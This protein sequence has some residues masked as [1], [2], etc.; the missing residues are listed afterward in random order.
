ML[1]AVPAALVT[2]SRHSVHRDDGALPD[3]EVSGTAREYGD[4]REGGTG[5]RSKGEEGA[6]G[7]RRYA[8]KGP[9]DNVARR[10]ALRESSEFG[11]IGSLG[12]GGVAKGGGG[13]GLGTGTGQGF[14][15]G[16]GR[17][18]GSALS[19]TPTAGG[20]RAPSAPW[21]RDRFDHAS[22][23]PFVR[24]KEDAR[25]TFSI[26][27]DTASYSWVRSQLARGYK[28][29]QG[30][31]RI[32]ELV[33]YFDYHY[34]QPTG[35][36]AFSVAAHVTE[37]PWAPRHRLLR[38]GIQ[39]K[40]LDLSH[41]PAANLVFLLD[42]SG[43]MQPENKLPLLK[44]GLRLLVDQLEA[45]DRVSIAVY[46]GAS[47][48]VLP[49]TPG[50]QKTRILHAIERLDAGGSTN[51]GEGIRLAYAQAKQS[52]MTGGINR[53]LLATDGDFNVG[54]TS[55][56]E[57]VDLIQKK[58]KQGVFLSVLGFGHGNYN[59][60][61]L[62]KLADKG[63]GNY[64]YI[65][66]LSEA[67]K[68]LVQQASGTLVTIAK[69]V[70]LQLEFN[71]RQVEAYRLIGYEN[72]V[73]EHR[74]FNDDRKDAG[75]LGAGHTVTALYEVI[76]AGMRVPE[77]SADG[78]KYQAPAGLTAA[79]D[80][81]EIVT[82]KLRYKAPDGDRSRLLEV[83]VQDGGSDFAGA[84]GDFRFAACVAAF[85]ML[86]RDSSYRGSWKLDDIR[87]VALAHAAG[88]EH[89]SEFV[90]LLDQARSVV[91]S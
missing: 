21:N 35:G 37:A 73:L 19:A 40:D 55:Q 9:R 46:A 51:G 15:S 22:E 20:W 5:M 33:N 60:A 65:D 86:L 71:P 16:H 48:L 68:V 76:P 27:V 77:V 56:S 72:R 39:G 61:T 64:A 45:R 7:N 84:S 59:D 54:V 69:D 57:L 87:R 34:P 13:L 10:S 25:S 17:L 11:A 6:M 28:P 12:A 83:P 1:L 41:R 44:R 3:S 32:E 62:E 38:I 78:L 43:S 14:G 31:V 52:F 58:A 90:S 81:A 50:D 88:D 79:A 74:D 36:A 53:V 66:K 85:G 89:R 29:P 63:N 49:P 82:V 70:K 24:V 30:A 23:N 2:H 67:R 91:G 47:G 26:D 75:E 80:T 8:I 42:V 18:G 4:D